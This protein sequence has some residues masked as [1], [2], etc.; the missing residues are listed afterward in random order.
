MYG[1]DTVKIMKG[2]PY[3][4]TIGSGILSHI[5]ELLPQRSPCIAALV[6]DDIVDHLYG[7]EVTAALQDYGYTVYHFVFPHG[8]ENKNMEQLSSLLSFLAESH[9][10]RSDLIVALGGGVTGDLAGLAAAI[11]LRGIEYVQIP[12]TF[13]AAIDSSVGGKTAVDLPEGKNLVGA[14]WQPMAVIC[15][16]ATFAT[17]PE[18][19]FIDG[20]AEAIKYGVLADPQMFELLSGADFREHLGQIIRRSVAIK[21]DFVHDDERDT[22]SRQLLNLGHTI[23]HAIEQCSSYTVAHGHAVAIGMVIIAK[24]AAATGICDS[25]VPQMIETALANNHLPTRC[26]YSL[27][28]LVDVI[29]T[30]KKRRG[31]IITLVVPERI[32]HCRLHKINVAEMASFIE[33]GLK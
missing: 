14:F 23:G 8:E 26:D 11:Y 19:V 33:P 13:L 31:D 17:L 30:D 25:A 5:G 10:S 1:T 9:L 3:E 22:G 6:S 24:A 21:G 18:N 16:T 20:T 4:V 7:N 32:G 15:D 2:H 28:R 29:Q 12:T 27:A